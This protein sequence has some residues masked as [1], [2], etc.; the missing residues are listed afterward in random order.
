LELEELTKADQ[1]L[2]ARLASVRQGLAD[3]RQERDR[4]LQLRD[5]TSTLLAELR[6]QRSGLASRIEVL[7]GLERSHEG[8]GTGVREVIALLEQPDPGP[9]RTVVGLIADFLTVSRE[10]APLIDL[11]LGETAQRFLVRDAAQ[12]H[13]A[14]SEHGRPLSGRVSFLPLG[15]GNSEAG[16]AR[17]NR[18]IEVSPLVRVRMPVSTRGRPPTPA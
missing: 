9:W 17:P 4:F 12:L 8:L 10:Y 16:P 11:A 18:L 14:L 7:E 3:Q 13:Q 15:P 6:A 2:Q 5:A 1:A